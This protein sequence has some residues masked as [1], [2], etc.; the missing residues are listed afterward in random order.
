MD[1]F[2][3]F[4]LL[5]FVWTLIS[6]LAGVIVHWW[7]TRGQ[8]ELLKAY[9]DREEA[10]ETWQASMKPIQGRHRRRK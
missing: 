1:P 4:L 9:E 3:W 8:R 6:F 7:A 10:H 5:A 2:T